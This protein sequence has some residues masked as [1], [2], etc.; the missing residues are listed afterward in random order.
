MLYHP[1]GGAE[2]LIHTVW[3]E[4]FHQYLAYAG[5]MIESSPW[6][7]E[8]HAKL[9][10]YSHFDRDGKIV[11]DRDVQAAAYV[12]EYAA[13]LA[14]NIPAVLEMDYLEFYDGTQEEIAAKYRIAWSMAYFLEVGAPKLPY[15]P[16]ER[17]RAKY[18]EALVRTRSMYGATAAVFDDETREAFISAWLDFWKRQ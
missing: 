18:V 5:S 11:F 2:Q 14:Q 12:H 6:F 4:A 8:G 17:L 3:H 7:N 16:F 13:E 15:R 10:E 9:F 1:E